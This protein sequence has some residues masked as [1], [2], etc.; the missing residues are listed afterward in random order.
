MPHWKPTMQPNDANQR[1]E[2][3]VLVVATVERF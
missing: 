2:N 3:A 1:V